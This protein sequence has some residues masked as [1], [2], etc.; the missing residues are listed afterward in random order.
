TNFASRQ[1]HSKSAKGKGSR[2]QPARVSTKASLGRLMHSSVTSEF[3]SSGRSARS[4]RP[5]ADISA[6]ALA[7]GGDGSE[8]IN[9]P[10]VQVAR[11]QDLNA[12]A[13]LLQHRGRDADGSL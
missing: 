3:A 4:V 7:I 12:F 5:S 2:C 9:R 11:H 6:P 10:E 8:F 13:L 1:H